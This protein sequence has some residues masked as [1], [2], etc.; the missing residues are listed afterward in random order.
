MCYRVRPFYNIEGPVGKGVTGKSDDILLVKF[1]LT[2][3]TSVDL[4]WNAATP[5]SKRPLS[6]RPAAS[7]SPPTSSASTC[8]PPPTSPPSTMIKNFR[9]VP[10]VADGRVDAVPRYMGELSPQQHAFYTLS[11]LNSNFELFFPKRFADLSRDE[12]TPMQ[13]RTALLN[14]AR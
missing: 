14:N 13:L 12:S 1:F 2:E 4:T 6:M 10:V 8:P 9:S 5:S 3:L 11:W 7:A